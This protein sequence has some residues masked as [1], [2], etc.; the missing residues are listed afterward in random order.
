M[1]SVEGN[2]FFFKVHILHASNLFSQSRLFL[3]L[4]C[5]ISFLSQQAGMQ[6]RTLHH[7]S[8]SYSCGGCGRISNVPYH[9]LGC[10]FVPC[11]FYNISGK[12]NSLWT[13]SASLL[14]GVSSI[15]LPTTTPFLPF[16]CTAMAIVQKAPKDTS[17]IFH[18]A[19][20][21]KKLNRWL[22][23]LSSSPVVLPF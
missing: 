12:A 21:T 18:Y 6:L 2:P 17:E 20:M 19:L 3:Y 5:S 1:V 11:L 14:R 13:K 8:A 7:T 10:L 22:R 9:A 4:V 23:V 15:W 16:G